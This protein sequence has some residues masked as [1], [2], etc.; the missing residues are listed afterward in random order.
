MCDMVKSGGPTGDAF[1]LWAATLRSRCHWYVAVW[2]APAALPSS[3]Q[4]CLLQAAAVAAAAAAHPLPVAGELGCVELKG[5]FQ[6]LQPVVKRTT[7]AAP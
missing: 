7:K 2:L 6:A 5:G 3:A 4:Q 1:L